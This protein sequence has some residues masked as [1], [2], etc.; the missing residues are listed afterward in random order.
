MGFFPGISG[1]LGSGRGGGYR[2]ISQGTL[3]S[4]ADFSQQ[5]DEFHLREVEVFDLDVGDDFGLQGFELH[6]LGVGGGAAL[7]FLP[8]EGLEAALELGEHSAG[9]GVIGDGFLGGFESFDGGMILE[10]LPEFLGRLK[11]LLCVY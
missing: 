11:N 7:L 3:I 4:L 1:G 6:F 2:R 5:I 8:A 10:H 9:L